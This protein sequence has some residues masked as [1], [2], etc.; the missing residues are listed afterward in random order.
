[1]KSYVVD[2]SVGAKWCLPSMDEAFVEEAEQLLES[3][4][5]K[6][7]GF[8]VPDL[9]WTEITNTLWKSIRKQKISLNDGLTA[10]S[11]VQASGIP[12]MPSTDFLQHALNI[13]AT[14]DRTVYDSLYVAMAVESSMEMVT[15]DEQLANALSAYFP[16]K[17]LG[18]ILI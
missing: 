15:A 12:T 8:I 4:K 2:A 17:L 7:I 13:A 1:M 6:E 18:A 11:F 5:S 3:F 10:L 16:V 9:F 14:Y